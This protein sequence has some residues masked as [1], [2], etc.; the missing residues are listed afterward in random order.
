MQDYSQTY[1]RAVYETDYQIIVF[2]F[3]NIVFPTSKDTNGTHVET[4][5]PV[6]RSR[7]LLFFII[8]SR[9]AFTNIA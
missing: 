4:T 6:L 7:V 2:F 3:L 9:R 8:F 1:S 5:L